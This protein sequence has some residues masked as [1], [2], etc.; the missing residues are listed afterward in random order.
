MGET[1]QRGGER[2]AAQQT[3]WIVGWGT[4]VWRTHRRGDG[5]RRA[6]WA[7]AGH[8]KTT[9]RGADIN[10][11]RESTDGRGPVGP[12]LLLACS[13]VDASLRATRRRAPSC[14]PSSAGAG[15]F[16]SKGRR[17]RWRRRRRRRREAVVHCRGGC[18]RC[19]RQC[20]VGHCGKYSSSRR[21][22]TTTSGVLAVT[23]RRPLPVHALPS[24]EETRQDKCKRP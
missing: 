13:V 15:V 8:R 1:L 16:Y 22:A 23:P 18:G 20:G 2:D 12:Q 19:H 9:A 11:G 24:W 7:R 6:A 21:Q 14:H 17:R 10:R 3:R 4:R 5:T